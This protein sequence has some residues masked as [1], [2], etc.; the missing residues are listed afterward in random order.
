MTTTPRRLAPIA[1]ASIFLVAP[2]SALASG[3]ETARFGGEHGTPADPNPTAVYYNPAALA[4]TSGLQ[5]LGEYDLAV[6]RAT[7]TH[8]HAPTDVNEPRGADGGNNGTGTLLNAVGAPFLGGSYKLAK[9]LAIGAAFYVPIGGVE[10]W[11]QNAIF[12]NSPKFAGP[13]DGAQRWYSITGEIVSMYWSLG[14]GYK[15]PGTGLSLGVSGNL[16]KTT[17]DTTRAR[18]AMGNDDIANETRAHLD[19]S[20]FQGSFG[21]GLLY[22][23][24]KE[25]LW[26]GLSYQARPNVSGGMKL[27]GT[28]NIYPLAV[29]AVD[30]AQKVSLYQEY[31]D[32]LRAGLRGKPTPDTEVRLFGYWERWS[33]FQ[34]Q[35][36]SA[37]DTACRV[38]DAG[39]AASG[40]TPIQNLP[41]HW[42]DGFG[43]R[44]GGSYW[45][46]KSIELIGG[47]GYDS[48][49]VPDSRLEP[50]IF[51]VKMV[52]LATGARFDVTRHL[53]VGLTYTNFFG[54]PRD[55]TGESVNAK[56]PP[57][58]T[59]PDA[60]GQ[61]TQYIGLVSVALGVQFD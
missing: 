61:Y 20:G 18:T 59:G 5:L 31:P 33:D 45:V 30:T 7:Y 47:V 35:C 55:T 56:L 32:I 46:R 34:N 39:A 1:L 16:I 9:G 42:Q 52:T 27:D 38:N 13:I 50:V 26:F 41:R 11:N 22:E 3:F 58:S 12:R 44:A 6:R 60:G 21:A 36:I 49:A 23:A 37:R 10:T 29:G 25:R 40:T 28:L 57:P 54:I 51:D 19:V 24:M 48:N 15:I 43:V 4:E 53:N 14:I 17:I 2:A 8:T